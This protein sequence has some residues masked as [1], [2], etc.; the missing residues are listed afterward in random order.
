MLERVRQRLRSLPPHLLYIGVIL[1]KKACGIK[2]AAGR[3]VIIDRCIRRVR[4]Q[5]RIDQILNGLRMAFR[6]L[7]QLLQIAEFHAVL[8][9]IEE[10]LHIAAH[11][12]PVV[13]HGLFSG[14]GE[15]RAV[16]L[17][18]RIVAA[19]AFVLKNA[20]VQHRYAGVHI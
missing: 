12:R 9:G 11:K 20:L 19:E 18:V 10:A 8:A 6:I 4:L 17:R 3:A 7:D 13:Q 15:S 1:I 16:F 5:R 2:A 14:G